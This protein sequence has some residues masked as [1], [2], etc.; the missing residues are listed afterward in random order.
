ML[1]TRSQVV[2]DSFQQS[3]TAITLEN[4]TP[5]SGAEAVSGAAWVR[6]SISTSSLKLGGPASPANYQNQVYNGTAGTASAWYYLDID[7]GTLDY[8]VTAVMRMAGTFDGGNL[9]SIGARMSQT[10]DTG[11]FASVSSSATYVDGVSPGVKI[12]LQKRVAGSS[13]TLAS[14]VLPTPTTQIN[15]ELWTL[16]LDCSND[17]KV[18]YVKGPLSGYTDFPVRV[19]SNTDNAINTTGNVGLYCLRCASSLGQHP[20]Y[21]KFE[22]NGPQQQ[23]GT[24][25]ASSPD[26]AQTPALLWTPDYSV[27]T[28]LV[29]AN[30]GSSGIWSHSQKPYVR[31]LIQPDRI[32]V[33]T[34]SDVPGS[35]I[36][37]PTGALRT[38]LRSIYRADADFLVTATAA[39]L[40]AD[41]T[42][43]MSSND[44]AQL[45]FQ[46][47]GDFMTNQST[48][49]ILRLSAAPSGT[50]V[51]VLRGQ[52]TT[53]ADIA[54]GDTFSVATGDVN[55]S[56]SSYE[57]SRAEVYDRFPSTGGSTTPTAWPD[58]VGS[59]RWYGFSALIPSDFD[60]DGYGGANPW[61]TLLQWKGQ[62]GGS[63]P[64]SIGIDVT[65]GA[66]GRWIL[67]GTASR[68]RQNLGDVVPGTWTRFVFGF[69][70][71][72]NAVNGWC[73]AYRDGNLVVPKRAEAT[74][75]P[76]G[77]GADP[78]YLKQGIYRTKYWA[79]THI[80]YYGAMKVGTTM[81]DVQD[82]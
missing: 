60:V 82:S 31:G 39:A 78:I 36:Y 25:P 17:E 9:F 74:M 20:T 1:R 28:Q 77:A 40:A 61:I 6:S 72:Y 68:T 51:P 54:I 35:G 27:A 81:A 49:E 65:R 29:G 55:D 57:T 67:D 76:H 24:A 34:G 64:R 43:T 3:L 12:T 70:W 37:K 42:L 56:G 79:A 62:Y 13:T 44:A 41:T 71:E 16:I 53:A 7:P 2:V 63:P 80:T 48:D 45:Q 66:Y 8:R 32:Q 21:F 46:T 11:Y 4:H 52:S 75:D 50:A 15:G 59:V 5:D 38:E 73:M 30:E 14:V 58:P 10:A 23:A 47:K 69:R 22:R 19:L 33:V 26:P 18:V